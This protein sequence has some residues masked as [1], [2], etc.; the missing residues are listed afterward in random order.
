[1][2]NK[3]IF[4]L[5]NNF[6]FKKIFKTLNYCIES[7]LKDC[8]TAL[9]IGCGPDSPIKHCKNLSYTVGVEPFNDY[10]E[11]SKK[12][13]IHNKYINKN[14]LDLEFEK[15][16]FD[17][18]LMIDIIEHM[19][20][21]KAKE[22]IIKATKWAKK[23]VIVST[24]NGFIEQGELDENSLQKHLCGFTVDDLNHMGFKCRGMAGLKFFRKDQETLKMDRELLNNIRFKPK[25]FFFI[26]TSVSQIIFY[27]FPK[28]S[29]SLFAIKL[30]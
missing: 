27:W 4:S 19:E 7:N 22:L 6:F 11:I 17:A 8:D 26:L 30:K 13:K 3:L 16:T 10:I 14:I 12:K 25:I 24:P 2:L 20:K 21:D 18:V 9:D 23:K 1:M 15:N 29:F 5:H 28:F